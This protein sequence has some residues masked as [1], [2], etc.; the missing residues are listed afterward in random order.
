MNEFDKFDEYYYVSAQPDGVE[1]WIPAA[2]A[3]VLVWQVPFFQAI[4]HEFF[5]SCCIH[6]LIYLMWSRLNNV[7][8]QKLVLILSFF[9]FLFLSFL[10]YHIM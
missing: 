7:S 1:V 4:F 3:V 2:A 10:F 6:S 5:F 9:P 8:Q